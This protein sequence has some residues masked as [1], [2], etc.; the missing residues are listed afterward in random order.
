[1]D[2]PFCGDGEQS[3]YIDARYGR[4]DPAARRD[5]LDLVVCLASG[6]LRTP[7]RQQQL[8]GWVFRGEEPWDE[9]PASP[10]AGQPAPPQNALP[11]VSPPGR[12]VPINRLPRRNRAAGYLAGRGYD[13]DELAGVWGVGCYA[14]ARPLRLRDRIYIPVVQQGALVGWQGRWPADLDW[15]AE[16]IPKYYTMPGLRK[17]ALLYNGD[18]AR[19]QPLVVVC[20]G[21]S[22]V[23]RVGPPGV[24]LLGKSA[25][26]EQLRLLVTS[27]AGRPAVVLLD[28]DAGTEA[29]ALCDRLRPYFGG[30]LVL[31][32][33][34]E[35]LDPGA[36]PRP[37]LWAFLRARAAGQGVELPDGPGL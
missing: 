8:A 7:R 30:R 16:G 22:D 20:E 17:G 5:N 28:A 10:P 26:P 9:G 14:G 37:Q 24:A 31:A 32:L 1:V 21:C 35:G 12:V 11:A 36:C 34:P 15:R 19:Q 27:W 2:C 3:L 23:W 13:L 33:L 18:V 25:S 6:C 4:Y 29:R